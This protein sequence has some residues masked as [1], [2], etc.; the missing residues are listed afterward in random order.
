MSEL[1]ETVGKDLDDLLEQRLH[2]DD[3]K[4]YRKMHD[5]H[6]WEWKTHR[7]CD[8]GSLRGLRALLYHSRAVTIAREPTL[9]E[10]A[11]DQLRRVG[12]ACRKLKQL[13]EEEANL[14]FSASNAIWR[15]IFFLEQRVA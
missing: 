6:F 4:S 13:N 11:A 8:Q 9:A 15:W 1:H 3:Y 14:V 10:G 2:P 7:I 5:Y 12:F